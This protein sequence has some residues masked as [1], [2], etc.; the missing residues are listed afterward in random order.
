MPDAVYGATAPPKAKPLR[1][2]SLGAGVQSTTVALMASRGVLAPPDVAI[3]AD[4]GWEPKRVYEHL[5]WLRTQLP[6][7]VHVVS[8]GNLRENVLTRQ[9][10]S[11]GRYAAIPYYVKNADG[12]DGL[13]RRQCTSEFKLK[14]IHREL[15]RLLGKG[16]NDA[17]SPGA[18]ELSISG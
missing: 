16:P 13:G 8:A 2:L 17:V 15:R 7:P 4:T 1:V 14:P 6:F 12:S 3:F 10:T 11:G 5:A 18:V 9:N